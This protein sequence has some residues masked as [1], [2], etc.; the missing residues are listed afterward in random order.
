VSLTRQLL[1]LAV[2]AAAA[3]AGWL[4]LDPGSGPAAVERGREARAVPIRVAEARLGRIEEAIEAVATTRSIQA[5]EI[6]PTV[7]GRVETIELVPGQKVAAG[8]TLVTL[9]AEAERAAVAE[10]EAMLADARGQFERAEALAKT[11]SMAAAR[12]DELRA[13]FLAARARLDVAA[14]RLAERRIVAPFDGIVGLRE[15][16]IGARV[17]DETVITTLDAIDTLEAEFSVPEQFFGRLGPDTRVRASAKAY[18]GR[19]FEGRVSGIDSRVDPVS[20]AFRVRAE[21]PNRDLALPAGLFMVVEIL[22][23]EREVV[24]VPEEAVVIEGRSSFVFRIA[25]GQAA[26][27]EV[28]LGQRRKGEVEIAQGLA[29]GDLVAVTGLQRLRDGARVEVQRPD[30][31]AAPVS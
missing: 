10:A 15:V 30:A 16:S 6:V 19:V 29:A 20:R 28:R 13:A 24:L 1:V 4:W 11:K 12:V 26:R 31:G 5:I 25:E 21:I 27:R 23:A 2:L 9:D 22:L 8:D 17:D 14:K 7:S 18:P 3:A